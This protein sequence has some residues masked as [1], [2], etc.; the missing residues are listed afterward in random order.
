MGLGAEEVADLS[1]KRRTEPVAEQQHVSSSPRCWEVRETLSSC[2]W[3]GDLET[4]KLSFP[5]KVVPPA[6]LL[7][8]SELPPANQSTWCQAPF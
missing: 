7:L 1:S 3:W 2:G 8:Y 5:L 6:H 4:Q